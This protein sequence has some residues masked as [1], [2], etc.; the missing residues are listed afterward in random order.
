MGTYHVHTS[1]SISSIF[2]L[3]N[4][5]AVSIEPVPQFPLQLFGDELSLSK[6]MVPGVITVGKYHVTELYL[7]KIEESREVFFGFE[8]RTIKDLQLVRN[9]QL[10]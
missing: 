4:R 8:A 7:E 3:Y 2:G 1:Y 9:G 10:E 5:F 6:V